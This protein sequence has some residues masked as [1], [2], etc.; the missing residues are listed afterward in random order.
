MV[1]KQHSRKVA[2]GKQQGNVFR[3]WSFEPESSRC[4]NPCVGDLP[5]KA[6]GSGTAAS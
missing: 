6:E 1:A 2:K 3:V 4:R 5:R